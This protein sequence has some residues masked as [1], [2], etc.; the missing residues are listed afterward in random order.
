MFD[1][2]NSKSFNFSGV[3]NNQRM[4]CVE[5]RCLVTSSSVIGMKAV[6]V[7]VVLLKRR[8][9]LFYCNLLVAGVFA[10]LSFSDEVLRP[11]MSAGGIS[12]VTPTPPA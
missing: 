7:T 12:L 11:A 3:P 5:F 10:T 6:I 4:L 1:C 2:I 8:S 9:N